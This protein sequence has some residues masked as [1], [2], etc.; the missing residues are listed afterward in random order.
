MNQL[1]EQ[2]RKEIAT[3]IAGGRKIQAIKLYREATGVDLAEAKRA[4]E[5][6][7][8]ELRQHLIEAVVQNVAHVKNKWG[9]TSVVVCFALLV[10]AVLVAIYILRS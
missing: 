5:D 10:S 1:T 3:E 9:C 8:K 4:V 2:Q 7:E 6:L